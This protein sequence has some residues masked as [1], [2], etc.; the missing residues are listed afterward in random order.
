M[1][2]LRDTTD[3]IE[4]IVTLGYIAALGFVIVAFDFCI[5]A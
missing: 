2:T 3:E 4:E 1:L 5:S